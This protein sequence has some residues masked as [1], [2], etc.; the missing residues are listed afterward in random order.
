MH[1][2]PH[3]NPSED[4]RRRLRILMAGLVLGF[5][6]ILLRL[7]YLQ[8]IE[9]ERFANLSESNRI[10]II[11][12]R[13]IRGQILD[14]YGKVLVDNRPSFTLSV[15]PEETP[16]LDL[17]IPRLK[18]HLP[19][20]PEE[21]EPK[22]KMAYAYRTI[23]LA[24]DLTR[25]QVAYVAEH[26]WDLPGVFLDV[27]H[28]RY[29]KYGELAA[30]TLGYIGEINEDQLREARQH[31]YRMGDYI[32]QAGV[33]KLFERP[34]RG[35]KGARE[36]EVDA[37][38]RELQL[39]Q[40]REPGPGMN[41]VLTLDIGLQQM[42]EEEM[43]VQAG[44]IVV[45][46]PR[47]G[48][49]LAM[50]SKP[51]YDPNLFVT[52]ITISNWMRLIKD[53][54]KPLQSRAIQAQYPPGSTYKIVMAVAGLEE[55]IINPKSTVHCNGLF[56]YGNRVF[57]DWKRGGHGPMNVHS[58]LVQSCDVF[59][60][61]LGH[62]L[63]IDTIARYAKG[64]G[65]GVP[66]GYDPVHE[67][68][69]LV[70]S[71]A[72]KRQARGEPWYPGETISA[73][74]GQG[75]NLVTPLQLLNV[76]S[77]VANGGVRYKPR[78]VKRLETPDGK[79][80][81]EFGPQKLG[82]IPARPET[83]R[84]VQ[85]ALRGVINEPRGTGWRGRLEQVSIAGK[86]GTVQV[87]SNSPKGDKLPERFRDHG[88]FI[89]YAP[90]E[91]PQLAIAILGEHGGRGGSTYAPLARKIVE[92]HFKLPATP[93]PQTPAVAQRPVIRQPVAAAGFVAPP[94]SNQ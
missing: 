30:H 9:G 64:F 17:L 93:A 63:G 22:V 41:L 90:F 14:R 61:T 67:K 6:V 60:Y 36:V 58:A 47:N 38:G 29:Y 4:T 1:Q 52:G 13:D 19:I 59:F 31:G 10:R 5:M 43:G 84:T 88:W 79:V 86:T 71:T 66:T 3:T 35:A 57:R 44:S 48:E 24:K 69:G 78:L 74:I 20:R 21:V 70:P 91:Q 65:L 82:D 76:I 46:D 55:G 51:S 32:G 50:V 89:A 85:E 92:Y 53:P 73:A 83:L 87:I 56:P 49:I 39:V 37:L 40:E 28:V 7:W 81:Q 18:D 77:S 27:E 34:L 42:I 15:L 68:S 8:V 72:W 2:R 80:V 45:M 94:G 11:P 62:R 26:R 33:E 54:R 16:K 75:Y 25:D 12:Q 23:Q